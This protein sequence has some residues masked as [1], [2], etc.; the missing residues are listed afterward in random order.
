MKK[1][2]KAA[3]DDIE[4]VNPAL[5]SLLVREPHTQ[6]HCLTSACLADAAREDSHGTCFF[7]APQLRR[8]SLGST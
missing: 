6:A 7:G 2:T 8:D 1:T 3:D 4:S 5:R